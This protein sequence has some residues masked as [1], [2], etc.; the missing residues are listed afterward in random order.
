MTKITH[1]F[2]QISHK[3]RLHR[4]SWDKGPC[5]WRKYNRSNS[6]INGNSFCA[7]E[8]QKHSRHCSTTPCLNV[9]RQERLVHVPSGKIRT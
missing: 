6:Q 4:D 2:V 8:L 3:Y 7:S 1:Q 5:R 9:M